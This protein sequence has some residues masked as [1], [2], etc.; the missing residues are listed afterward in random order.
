MKT[1]HNTADPKW[2]YR[3]A[4]SPHG[5][6]LVEL[7]VVIAIIGILIGMM[8]PAVQAARES[9]RRS[10]CTSNLAQLILAVH[11]YESAHGVYPPGTVNDKGP[12]RNE[13]K[14]LHHNWIVHI[15]PYIEE[16]NAY[17]QIDQ[18]A[19]VYAPKNAPVRQL[20]IPL[21]QC[22]SEAAQ[23]WN[24]SGASSY[25]G[26][27]HDVEA[28]IDVDNNGVFFLNSRLGYDDIRDG[29]SH[30]I[31]LAE[32]RLDWSDLGWM[33][34]T[35]A[36]L[37]NTGT[38]INATGV[39]G[40][41]GGGMPP[42]DLSQPQAEDEVTAATEEGVPASKSE[43]V[44]VPD[45]ADSRQGDEAAASAPSEDTPA[46]QPKEVVP[47]TKAVQS[48][49]NATGASSPLYVG[50]FGSAH[51]V[52][53]NVAFGDGNVRRLLSSSIDPQVL[54]QLGHRADGKLLNT[55]S[56]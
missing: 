41:G 32:K 2:K 21:L 35:R 15:L 11:S 29:T 48:P 7:L 4:T 46:G 12:I 22:P 18:S 3:Y 50:G 55:I 36:T 45:S 16:G 19:S 39:V 23:T 25:A 47:A 9:A 54:R 40:V 51:P 42:G 44:Q 8:L 1:Q 33:S 10:Q 28:P 26:S 56:P 38:P 43:A 27:H 6:T 30:T 17:H 49:A 52:L 53:A 5:F 37:R 13:P 20:T 34:G 31:F 24:G 14:G